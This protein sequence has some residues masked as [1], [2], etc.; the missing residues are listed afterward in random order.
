V[1]GR[2]VEVIQKKEI[3]GEEQRKRKQERE[4]ER[5]RETETE[6]GREECERVKGRA[7]GREGE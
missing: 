5:G 4:E 2:P 6:R 7:G 3:E 1:G